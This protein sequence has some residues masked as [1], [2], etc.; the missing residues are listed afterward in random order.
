MNS[1]NGQEHV[2]EFHPNPDDGK[3]HNVT[4][5]IIEGASGRR[6]LALVLGNHREV[7]ADETY[8]INTLLPEQNATQATPI[9]ISTT[10]QPEAAAT[11]SA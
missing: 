2:V 9:P 6:F 11:V 5:A 3:I 10:A 1:V 4:E 7:K 8:Q